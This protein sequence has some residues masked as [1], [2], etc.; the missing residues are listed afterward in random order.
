M[1]TKIVMDYHYDREAPD[2]SDYY[3]RRGRNWSKLT[4]TTWKEDGYDIIEVVERGKKTC[5]WCALGR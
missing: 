5:D 3:Q 2:R 4:K 1:F